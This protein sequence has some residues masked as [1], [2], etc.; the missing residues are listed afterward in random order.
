MTKTAPE[1][2]LA[3]TTLLLFAALL[4]WDASGLDLPLAHWFGNANGFVLRDHWL[5]SGVLHNGARYASWVLAL[6]LCVAVGWPLGWLRRIDFDAR[7]Q[8][9][10]TALL[11]V[12]VVSSLKS[13]SITSCPWDL[14]EFGRTARHLSHWAWGSADGGGGRCFP[15]GHASAGFAFVA[16]YFAFRRRAPRVARLWLAAAVGA[17]LVLGMAQQVRG[18]HFMS[19]TLWTGWLCWATA[20]SVDALV[21]WVR[22][23]RA[24]APALEMR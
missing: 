20:L 7:L 10:A 3:L 18:A 9:A 13:L 4:A 2:H 22:Q 24:V 6:W 8:L 14:A 23:R 12:S 17:G 1:P 11:A 19:H 21:T 16:G 5:F 15:A